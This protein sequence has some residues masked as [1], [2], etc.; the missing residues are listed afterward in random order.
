MQLEDSD[1]RGIF[2]TPLHVRRGRGLIGAAGVVALVLPVRVVGFD[3]LGVADLRAGYAE[4]GGHQLDI[5][6]PPSESVSV[7]SIL[8]FYKK[9]CAPS[10]EAPPF[11]PL[12]R[13]PSWRGQL[14][15]FAPC[16][17]GRSIRLG[18]GA[19]IPRL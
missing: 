2:N 6:I 12:A 9:G 14:Q 7:A 19:R 16:L 5:R 18:R 17:P 3:E 4:G 11:R 8:L 10:P 15:I 1:L 13:Q